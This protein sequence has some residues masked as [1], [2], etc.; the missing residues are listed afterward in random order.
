MSYVIIVKSPNIFYISYL[1]IY[2]KFLNYFKIIQN[3][4]IDLF[5][6][7]IFYFLF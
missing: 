1:N 2:S 7:V 3:Y 4:S 5:Y 6:K